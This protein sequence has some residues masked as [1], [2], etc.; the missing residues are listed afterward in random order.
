[1]KTVYLLCFGCCP[2][3]WQH[4]QPKQDKQTIFMSTVVAV[5]SIA[6]RRRLPPKLVHVFYCPFQICV[7]T[8]T[9]FFCFCVFG[10]WNPQRQ[11]HMLFKCVRCS[12]HYES[13]SVAICG[14]VPVL[15][16]WEHCNRMCILLQWMLSQG[17]FP[18]FWDREDKEMIFNKLQLL[19]YHK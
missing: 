15:A 4:Q 9:F 1:M 12:F 19:K 13:C 2:D 16:L 11:A 7:F 14:I 17:S 5:K 8:N 10:F 18:F 3:I 6:L